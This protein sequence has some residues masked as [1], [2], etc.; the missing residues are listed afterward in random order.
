MYS[1]PN[2]SHESQLMGTGTTDSEGKTII[3]LP[4]G[5]YDVHVTATGYSAYNMPC[6]FEDVSTPY[7][8]YLS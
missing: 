7:T 5:E 8:A 3:Y 2:P 6:D 1:V 4:F